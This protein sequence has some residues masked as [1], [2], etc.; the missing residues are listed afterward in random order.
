M[1]QKF[2]STPSADNFD[3]VPEFLENKSCWMVWPERTDNWRLG[4]KPAQQ[5][6]T[7]IAN[8][9]IKQ[10]PVTMLVSKNQFNNARKQ[11]NEKI[12]VIEMSTNDCFIRDYGPIFLQNKATKEI[13]GL[14][15]NFNAWG[16]EKSGIYFPWN[17]D[18]MV[19]YKI[20]ELEQINYYELPIVL[21]P[22]MLTFD[23]HGTC[24]ASIEG[25]M[26]EDRNPHLNQQQMENYL[27]NYLNVVNIIWIPF[28]LPYDET[29][30]RLDNIM[31]VVNEKI[32]LLSWTDFT[33]DERYE[34]V[35]G[36]FDVL[37]KATNAS[38]KRYTIIKIPLP[39]I[40]NRNEAEMAM[41]DYDIYHNKMML[42]QKIVSSYTMLYI[43]NNAVL[44]PI[45]GDIDSQEKMLDIINHVFLKHRIILVDV[46]EIILGK[47]GLH[48]LICHQPLIIKN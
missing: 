41:I 4:A 1:A 29:K 11:L 3:V 40:A 45:F 39:K 24:F 26:S 20:F 18:E 14:K 46:R 36:A 27:K 5:K 17:Y 8:T 12:R 22:S 7:E 13:R 6:I 23:G 2:Y 28:G 16:G 44:I 37:S 38:G 30:G 47:S 32:I 33:T 19:G 9:I 31:C 10:E 43:T 35:K 42:D 15:F 34:A 25:I 48:S 21:E